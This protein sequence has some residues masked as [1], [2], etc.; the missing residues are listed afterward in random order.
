M[1]S[2]RDG[3]SLIGICLGFFVVLLDATIVNVAL[4]AI[5]ASLGGG[6]GGQQWVVGSYTV[7]F[8]ALLLSAGAAGDRWGSRRT[9]LLGLALLAGAGV[10]CALAGDL[11]QLLLARVVQGAG[12]ALVTPCSLALIRQRFPEERARARALGGWGGIS[13]I[14][15]A[16]GPVLGGLLVDAAGWRAVFWAVVPFALLAAALVVATTP[17]TPRRT[18]VRADFVGQTLAA[19]ALAAVT[20]ALVAGPSVG[21]NSPAALTAAGAGLASAVGFA[22]SQRLVRAPMIPPGLFAQ[23]LFRVAVGV[24]ALFN[25]GLYG[26]LFCL[27]LYLERTLGTSTRTTGLVLLPLTVVVAICAAL[28]GRINARTGPR[29]PML[30]GLGAGVLGSAAL[31]GMGAGSAP[32]VVGAAAALLGGVGLAMPAMTSVAVSA[33]PPASAGLGAGVLNAAR[34]AGG[35]VGVAGLGAILLDPAGRPALLGAMLV[36]AGGYVLAMLLTVGLIRT[37]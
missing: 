24:G 21:W 13:G 23:R 19:A 9:Y 5:E 37:P 10:A 36:V 33:V 6:L 14:G 27:A 34:Q 28:S 29:V 3:W 16:A 4:G 32:V 30:L 35:A 20:A 11:S 25:F 2:A 18:A 12:A 8:G 7:A 22:A 31:A 26:T 1:T 17:E 15:L